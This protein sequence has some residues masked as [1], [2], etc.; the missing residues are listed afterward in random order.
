MR[1]LGI[2]TSTMAGSVAIL[3]DERVIAEHTLHSRV[4]HTE[5]LLAAIDYMLQDATLRIDEIDAIA[6]SIG[7]GSFTGLRIGVTTAKSLAYSLHKPVIGIPS[8]DALA[9]HCLFTE[10]MI[11]PLLDARKREVYAA[12][13][14]NTGGQINRLSDY[15]VIA[16]EFLFQ[17]IPEPVL[18]LGDGVSRYRQVIES[19]LGE[20]ALFADAAHNTPRASLVAQLG[21]KRLMDGEQDDC[22]ML[23]PLYVRKSDAEIHWEHRHRP[24]VPSTTPL[25]M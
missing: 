11:C 6:V 22:F 15:M 17:Q 3:A 13:Y 18:V 14:R 5:R 8:L 9:A 25:Y 19:M 10:H 24:A 21:Y 16:P 1:I 20:R 4:T 12:L 2:E 23:T 7:P